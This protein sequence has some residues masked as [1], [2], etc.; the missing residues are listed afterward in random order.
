MVKAHISQI[1]IVTGI[2]T[3]SGCLML[4]VPKTMLRRVFGQPA[5]DA[6][7]TTITRHWGLLLF[8][9]GALL[10]YA[11][12]HAEVQTPVLIVGAVEK[13]AIATLVYTSPLRS[14][15]LLDVIVGADAVMGLLYV[16][17]LL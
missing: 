16:I 10:V 12:Y 5:P 6:V 8:L 17:A 2:L 11:G 7:T 3:L 15:R 13:L 9:V 14:R 4:L 1:L